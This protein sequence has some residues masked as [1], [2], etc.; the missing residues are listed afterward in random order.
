MFYLL[1]NDD[2][3]FSEGLC[4]LIGVVEKLGDYLVVAPDKERSAMSHAISISAP[5]LKLQKIR[6][7]VYSFSGTPA[8]CVML[9]FNYEPFISIKPDWVISGINKGGNVGTDVVYSGTVAA[10]IE[11]AINGCKGMAVSLDGVDGA[12]EIRFDVAAKVVSFLLRNEAQLNITEGQVLNVNIPNIPLEDIQGI[13]LAIVGKRYYIKPVTKL[14]EE[15]DVIYFKIGGGKRT[16]LPIVDSDC[17]LVKKGYITL[18]VLSP[19]LMDLNAQNIFE[20]K[21]INEFFLKTMNKL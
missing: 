1:S 21:W 5:F 15:G 8:D 12:K 11:G 17:E 14:S 7:N 3:V 10:A 13:R 9:A 18:S 16:H 19:S 20:D 4:K 2:G 6:D